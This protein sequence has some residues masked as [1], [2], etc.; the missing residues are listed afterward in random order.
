MRYTQLILS[1]FFFFTFAMALPAPAPV[2][3]VAAA[4]KNNNKNG[5]KANG[6]KGANGRTT[7]KG[8]T[9]KSNAN[10]GNNGKKTNANGNDCAAAN[11]LATGIA[12]NIAVQKE[13]QSDANTLTNIIKS[14]NTAGFASAKQKFLNTITRGMDIRKKNQSIAPKNNAAIAG[15]NKV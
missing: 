11:K 7:T 10:N 13:E 3:A 5:T 6:T 14:G 15:L 8:T 4:D 1:L 2:E 9:A 12:N